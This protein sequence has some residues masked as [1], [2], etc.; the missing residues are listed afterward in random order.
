[1]PERRGAPA[2]RWALAVLA[3][4]LAAGLVGA[5]MAWLLI[6]VQV[7]AY[8]VRAETLL[9]DV[10]AA[11][12]WR[13]VLAPALGGLLAGL[14]WWW[15]RRGGE[16]LGVEGALDAPGRMGL[17]RPFADA[18]L[19]LLVVGSGASIGREG[20]PRLAAGAVADQLAARL[21]LEPAHARAVIASGAGA[22]LAAVYNVPLAGVVFALE[23]VLAWRPAAAV[24]SALPMS[25][26]A[27]VVA[28]PVVS[29]RPTYAFPDVALDPAALAWT[30][31]AIPLTAALGLAFGRLAAASAW[32][33]PAPGPWLPA[34]TAGAGAAVGLASVWL[35]ML[36]GNGKDL[37]QLAFDGQLALA[38]CA[39]L[40]VAKPLATALCLRSGATGGL[41]TPA[42][43]TGAALGGV[44]ASLLDAAGGGVS[45][46]PLVLIAAAGVLAVTQRA[47]LFGAVMAWELTRAPLWTI[48][49]LLAV[50]YGSTLLADAA[51]RRLPGGRRPPVPSREADAQ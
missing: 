19:Q 14:G 41:L 4:G 15:L 35:P 10:Q 18:A 42:L 40:L 43:A 48:P 5:A 23:L 34:W 51:E 11:P 13:R 36:P 7:L 46:A 49:C 6:Q 25:A 22:G 24:A 1:M 29:T 31:A 20:A 50:A 39:V 33:R 12:P 21:R 9:T 27:T 45:G 30:A 8:G 3:G 17:A 2:L 16:P 37:M 47:P 44:A 26:I 32:R 28:W 38:A